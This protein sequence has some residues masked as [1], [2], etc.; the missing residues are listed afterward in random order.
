[1]SI[2]NK[3]GSLLPWRSDRRAPSS[4]RP[5][6]FAL[7]EDLDRWLSGLL[8]EPPGFR[9]FGGF[10]WLPSC[11][12]HERNDELIVTVEV[13]GLRPEDLDLMLTREGLTI[14][15]EKRE[16]RDDKR[17]GAHV[18]ERR[19]GSFVRTVQLPPGVDRDRAEARVV[20]GVLTVRLPKVLAGAGVRR[21]PVRA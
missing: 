1:M 5:E 15:G 2:I 4:D 19:Y 12:L 13:P 18:S 10:G 3:V 16:G 20:D 6:V 8:E 21:V 14:R 11:E 9:G 17:R 7:R